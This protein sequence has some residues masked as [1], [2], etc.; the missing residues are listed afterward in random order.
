ME[1]I[2][3]FPAADPDRSDHSPPLQVANFES[4]LDP[5]IPPPDFPQE[6]SS[7]C[8]SSEDVDALTS[9]G[10]TGTRVSGLVSD[11][12]ET[13]SVAHQNHC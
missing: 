9:G 3:E 8:L 11:F 1:Y 13:V 10:R 7:S 12:A 2:E 4:V 6:L 5:G